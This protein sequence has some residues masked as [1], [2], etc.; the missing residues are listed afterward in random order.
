MVKSTR[1]GPY[2]LRLRTF[3]LLSLYPHG[4]SEGRGTTPYFLCFC[5]FQ[6]PNVQPIPARSPS[7]VAIL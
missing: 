3:P 2:S 6:D 4:L 1:K 7:P 5:L